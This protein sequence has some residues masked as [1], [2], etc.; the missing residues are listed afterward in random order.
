MGTRTGC[1]VAAGC[2]PARIEK[3]IYADKSRSGQISPDK[4]V[5]AD[6]KWKSKARNVCGGACFDP[7]LEIVVLLEQACYSPSFSRV[8]S[9]PSTCSL[10][11]TAPSNLEPLP[12]S[13]A[14]ST[15]TACQWT[16]HRLSNLPSRLFHADARIFTISLV[17]VFTDWTSSRLLLQPLDFRHASPRC[18]LHREAVRQVRRRLQRIPR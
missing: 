10:Y 18:C 2:D 12:K 16:R 13:P 14:R 15:C 11:N 7:V 3:I 17:I 4:A 8:C 6:G 1:C 9:P 5:T